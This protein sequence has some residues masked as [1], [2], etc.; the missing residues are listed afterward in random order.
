ME[1]KKKKK[2][3][4]KIGKKETCSSMDQCKLF[5]SHV[6][7]QKSIKLLYHISRMLLG[8]VNRQCYFFF[9]NFVKYS[10]F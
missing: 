8:E 10:L 2:K 3:Q 7:P 9:L 1:A 5:L 4:D 6:K